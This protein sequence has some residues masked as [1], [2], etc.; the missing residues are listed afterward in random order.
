MFV[1]GG[2]AFDNWGDRLEYGAGVG[3]RYRTP[4]GV[5]RVDIAQGTNGQAAQVLGTTCVDSSNWSKTIAIPAWKFV[6]VIAAVHALPGTCPGTATGDFATARPATMPILPDPPINFA[7]S[8]WPNGERGV[9]RSRDGG[10]SSRRAAELR[11]VASSP[12][13]ARRS[14]SSAC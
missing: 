12:P 13:R 7:V 4:L 6:N 14:W 2:N 8:L 9:Y 10:R 5:L 1:D 3:A 11:T